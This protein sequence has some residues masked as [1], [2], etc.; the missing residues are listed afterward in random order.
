MNY[1][2]APVKS[3]FL[4]CGIAFIAIA[5]VLLT[6]STAAAAQ[7]R[8]YEGPEFCK[9]C[10][11]DNYNEWKASGHPYKLMKGEEAQ[12]RPIPLPKGYDWDDISYV[13]GGYKWKSRY[14]DNEGYIITNDDTSQGGN[15]QYNYL[16]GQ[17]SDYHAD[18]PNGTKP[19]NCGSCHTTAWIANENPED[20]SGNQDG[21]PG[22]GAPVSR[23][24]PGHRSGQ[25]RTCARGRRLVWPG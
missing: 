1:L 2:P 15:T 4:R 23:T 12:F 17:W 20:L 16:T 7:Y 14:M 10:H 24:A 22:Q 18:E 25:P 21:L 5:A 8:G 6:F 11:E 9:Q 3:P 19:Y 13:I